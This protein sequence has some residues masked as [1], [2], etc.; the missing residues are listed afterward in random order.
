MLTE[1]DIVASIKKIM[2]RESKES[3]DHIYV[4]SLSY[5]LPFTFYKLMLGAE[6]DDKFYVHSFRGEKI[7][8]AFNEVFETYFDDIVAEVP[9]NYR[10]LYGRVD[11]LSRKN[12]FTIEFKTTVSYKKLPF[13]WHWRQA[14]YYKALFGVERGYLVYF[15]LQSGE[16]RIFCSERDNVA[17]LAE[18]DERLDA[19]ETAKKL[20]DE[21]RITECLKCLKKYAD[22]SMCSFCQFRKTG[23]CRI[24]KIKD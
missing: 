21:H 11:Y 19:L 24:K 20:H 12:K 13:T 16:F 9:V 10:N 15:V 17:I 22:S 2:E 8:K 5:C 1:E 7:H 23:I 14:E 18:I 4:T 3:F 6:F